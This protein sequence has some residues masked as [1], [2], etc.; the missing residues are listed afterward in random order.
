[1]RASTLCCATFLSL[2]VTFAQNSESPIDIYTAALTEAA[3]EMER[4]W[5][6]F[7]PH[8]SQLRIDY[9]HRIVLKDDSVRAEYPASS[10]DIRFEY[11]TLSECHAR[12]RKIKRDFAVL[13]VHPAI[14]EGPRVK[15][16]VSQDWI[17]IHKGKP[18]LGISDWGAVLFRVDASSGSKFVLDEIK[19]GGI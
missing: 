16:L 19:L 2:S 14:V 5:S 10:G 3:K 11:L 9:R 4:Q 17:S 6:Q 7:E 12:R 13:R 18:A 15:V 8:E 1:M